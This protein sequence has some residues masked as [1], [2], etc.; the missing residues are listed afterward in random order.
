MTK[1]SY[2]L[3]DSPALLAAYKKA[4][5]TFKYFWREVF[6]EYHRIV[7]ALDGAYVKVIFVQEANERTGGNEDALVEHMWINEVDFDGD[8]IR[9]TLINEPNELTNVQE[10]DSVAVPLEAVS[11][12]LFARDDKTY[13]GFTIHLM[14]SEMTPD[15]R[16]EHDEAWGLNFG[17]FNEIELVVD[18][19]NHPEN[20]EEH[21]MSRNMRERY[22]EAIQA[23]PAVLTAQDEAGYT[24][25]HLE[26]IAGNKTSVE[27]LLAA[28]APTNIRTHSGKTALDF[29]RQ[30]NWAQLIPL[31]EQKS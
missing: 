22:K 19:K 13:G 16:A 2:S 12:W 10:G 23:N 20:L 3:N 14:R 15:E 5:E 9:G 4:R 7:P 6:T 26:A 1:D 11:D 28:G 29:A 17:D 24:Q 8:T 27:V 18:Q 31:L 21:P 30:L 25:L